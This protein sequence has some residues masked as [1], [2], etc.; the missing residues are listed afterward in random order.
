MWALVVVALLIG[1]PLAGLSLFGAKFTA[2]QWLSDRVAARLNA[3]IGVGRLDLGTVEFV[4]DRRIVPRIQM[5]HVGLFDQNGTEVAQVNQVTAR[6]SPSE[7]LGGVA[8]MDSIE[9]AGAVITVRRGADGAINLSFGAGAGTQ[10]DLASVLDAMDQAFS[11]APLASLKEVRAEEL[12]ISLEDARSGGHWQVTGGQILLQHNADSLDVTVSAEVFNGTEDLA[13]TVIGFRTEKGSARATL[14]ATFEDAAAADIAAQSPVLAFLEVLDAPI[15]GAL[16]TSFGEDGKIEDLA[17]TLNIGAGALQPSPDTPPIAFDFGQAYVDYDPD[18]ET[19]AFTE[20]SFQSEAASVT[21]EGTALLQGVATGWPE[22][23][24]GQ[25][26]VSQLELQPQDFLAEPMSFDR[27]AFDFRLRLDPFSVDIGQVSLGPPERRLLT[28]GR[29]RTDDQGWRMALDLNLNEMSLERILGLWP[30]ALAPGARRWVDKNVLA[31]DITDLAAALRIGTEREPLLSLSFLYDDALIKAV[32]FLPPIKGA[33]GYASLDANS[34][35]IVAERGTLT[36][37]NGGEVD[38]AGTVFR[39]GDVG[40]G[41]NRAEVTIRTE[42]SIPAALSL[43]DQEPLRLMERA[44]FGVDIA[45]GRAIVDAALEFDL[46]NDLAL[47]DIAYNVTG[48]LREVSSDTLIPERVVRAQELDFRADREGLEITGAAT[49]DGLPASGTWTQKF[50]TGS[51]GSSRVEGTVEL[52]QAFLDTFNIAL[53]PG[54]IS[55]QGVAQIALEFVDDAPPEFALSSDLNQVRL[56]LSALNW[57][58]PRNQTGQLEI[59]GRLGDVPRIDRLEINTPGLSARGVIDLTESGGLARAQFDRV[60]VGTWLDGPVTLTGRGG[61]RAPAVAVTGGRIDLR[62][63]EIGGGEGA[64]EG[65][66]LSMTL[67]RLT[68]SEGITLTGFRGDFK[69]GRGM[70]GR[71]SARVNGAAPIR[72]TVV[73]TPAGAAIRII[74]DQAGATLAA[75]GILRNA[76]GGAMDLTLNPSRIAGV[77][78]GR[79]SIKNTRIIEAPAMTELLNA[80]SIVGLLDQ[81]NSGGIGLSDVEAEFRLS[82]E[83][84]VL[85]GSSAVGPSI[86]VSLDGTYDLKNDRLDMQGVISPV[87][88]LNGIGQIFSRGR[89]GLFGFNFRLRGVAEN[90]SVSVNPLSILTPGAFR[91]IFRR[92]PP[93][94][95]Q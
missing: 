52:S 92:P 62:T 22:A 74:S 20:L 47:K 27:G 88:F 55:G 7:L 2:P 54:S 46:V 30:V 24:I 91:D 61:N 89:D 41:V 18:T 21:A 14:T 40:P 50:G 69:P 53:P 83:R 11:V 42:S 38:V 36:A 60:R 23:L 9:V 6:L 85:Y 12:T 75:A 43:I 59:S 66:P 72:G 26:R 49:L 65:G 1:A 44:G 45:E 5:R 70:D 32:D 15:S 33:A 51:Q 63:A 95:S 58:K 71:F 84:L 68:I 10:G 37:P 3:E 57:S 56:R 76:R 29:I 93:T 19:L 8:K 77:Y 78:D 25:F 87:Y 90:P 35:T 31:G 39:I 48:K 34:F 28:S 82:P 94:P 16:R 4:F 17:G 79:L 13:S 86:G 80:I 67:D 81:L 73:P 64:D